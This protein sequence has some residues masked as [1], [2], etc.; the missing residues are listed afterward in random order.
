[1]LACQKKQ[2]VECRLLRVGGNTEWQR[3]I[4]SPSWAPLDASD[5]LEADGPD[6]A[7]EKA[8]FTAQQALAWRI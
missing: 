2:D 8:A 5:L 4:S 3:A 7:L 1:V 6:L